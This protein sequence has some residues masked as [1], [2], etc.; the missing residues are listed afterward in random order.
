M[1]YCFDFTTK[2]SKVHRVLFDEVEGVKTAFG[3]ETADGLVYRADSVIV[4][5]GA[6][7]SPALLMRSGIGPANHLQDCGIPVV[8]D[9]PHVGQHLRDK[10]L[11]DD[12]ILTDSTVGGYAMRRDIFEF[13][14]A[15][16]ST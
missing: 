1:Q 15:Y 16:K 2:C 3:V 9:N 6:L 13:I 5:G 14:N 12:M 7:E 8:V 10:M 4:A 11:L